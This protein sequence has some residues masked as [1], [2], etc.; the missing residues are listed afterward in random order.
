MA[1]RS[2]SDLDPALQPLAQTFLDECKADPLFV[3]AGAECFLS[4]TYRSNAEQA[5]DW[6]KGRDANGNVIDKEA[7]IT[8]EP[9]GHSAHNFTTA[10]GTPCARAFDFAIQLPGTKLDW[11]GTDPLWLRAISIGESLGLVSGSTWKSPVDR[12]HFEMK[13]WRQ[14]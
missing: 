4:C 11:S 14:A 13:N 7:I 10:A 2:I 12:P 8:D 9:P 5:E 1:S 3:A 6:Q